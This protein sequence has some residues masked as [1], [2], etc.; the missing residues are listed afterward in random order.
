MVTSHAARLT[1]QGVQLRDK[2]DT[3]VLFQMIRRD[4]IDRTLRSLDGM[5][6]FAYRDGATGQITLARDKFGEKPLF[7]A[8]NQ[9]Q[10][11]FAS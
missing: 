10:F 9:G 6:A 5:F 3:E 2:S 8:L 1:E 4:G 7:Y 11:L